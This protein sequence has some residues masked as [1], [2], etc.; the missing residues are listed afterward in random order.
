MGAIILFLC[1]CNPSVSCYL[2][3]ILFA[4]YQRKNEDPRSL[5][6]NQIL[7]ILTRTEA[8][9]QDRRGNIKMKTLS[10][11]SI[12]HRVRPKQAECNSVYKDK[13]ETRNMIFF[14]HENIRTFTTESFV[15]ILRIIRNFRKFRNLTLRWDD[16]SL[17]NWQSK[18]YKW[19]YSLLY[20]L[21]ND[22]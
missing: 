8:C 7:C 4:N 14:I 5:R 10:K 17:F 2:C 6:P 12:F 19:N 3:F 21:A 9:K 15:Y 11:P 22:S 20:F 16:T 18:I 13:L 1:P